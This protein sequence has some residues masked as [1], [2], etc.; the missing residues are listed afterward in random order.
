MSS[1]NLTAPRFLLKAGIIAID[2][3]ESA[4]ALKHLNTILDKY[5]KSPEADKAILYLGKAE[6]MK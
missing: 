6:A 3:G 2:L 1:S 5:P 4:I